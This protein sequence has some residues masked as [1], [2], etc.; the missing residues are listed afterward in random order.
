MAQRLY[1]SGNPPR[2]ITSKPGYNASPALENIYKTFDSDWFNGAGIRWIFRV[3]IP[4]GIASKTVT[5]PYALDHVPKYNWM[6][7]GYRSSGG[8]SYLPQMRGVAW[9]FTPDGGA[10]WTTDWH[11]TPGRGN[12]TTPNN[13]VQ[14]FNDRFE[15]V[16]TPGYA[17]GVFGTLIVYQS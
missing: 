11:A 4:T 8:A 1:L 9:P 15:I 5:F 16:D 13:R 7:D 6:W 12:R 3:D 2:L 10:Y 17:G 14:M